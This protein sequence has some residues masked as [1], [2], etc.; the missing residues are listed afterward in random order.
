M[1]NLSVLLKSWHIMTISKNVFRTKKMKNFKSKGFTLIELLVVIA[2]IG[3][4]STIAMTSLT[5]AKKKANDAAFK[6]AVTGML[7]AVTMCCDQSG[8]PA[9]QYVAGSDVCNPAIGTKV[10]SGAGTVSAG[11]CNAGDWT[12]SFAAP[13]GGNC[14]STAV[15]CTP[16]GC[17][18]SAAGC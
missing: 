11:S 2:I 1:V 14:T 17:T 12:V 7:P 18:F 8:S 15:P 4:L 6:S 10:P 3:I 13:A 16:N 9:I 5:S